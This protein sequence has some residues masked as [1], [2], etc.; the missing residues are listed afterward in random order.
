M[1]R[2]ISN[3]RRL[4]SGPQS[5]IMPGLVCPEIATGQAGSCSLVA[6]NVGLPG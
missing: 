2:A 4:C 3:R 6:R 1:G 5:V